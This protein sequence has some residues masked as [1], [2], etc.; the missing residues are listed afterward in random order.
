[1]TVEAGGDDD[2]KAALA[3]FAR[4]LAGALGADNLPAEAIERAA[5]DPAFLHTLVSQRNNPTAVAFLLRQASGHPPK[6][7]P[8][9]TLAVVLHAVAALARWSVHGFGVVDDAT[10]QQR[11]T[12]CRSCPNLADAGHLLHYRLVSAEPA[13]VCS[14]CGCAVDRKTLLPTET[15]LAPDPE[16]PASTRWGDPIGPP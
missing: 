8:P 11:R 3:K 7:A 2:R 6:W 9:A 15:C 1:M 14:L 12:A 16:D 10:L 13:Q 4:M 5:A